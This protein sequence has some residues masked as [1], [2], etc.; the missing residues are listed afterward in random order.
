MNYPNEYHNNNPKPLLEERVMILHCFYAP[1]CTEDVDDGF[2]VNTLIFEIT[3][4]MMS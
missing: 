1:S 3:P 2:K 4:S